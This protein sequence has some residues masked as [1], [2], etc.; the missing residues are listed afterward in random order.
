MMLPAPYRSRRSLGPALAGAALLHVTVFVLAMMLGRPALGPVGVAVPITVVTRGPTTDSRRAEAARQVQAAQTEEPQPD[1]RPPEPPPVAKPTPPRPKAA[2]VKTPP[3]PPRPI[4]TPKPSPPKAPPKTQAKP[5]PTKD[6]FSLEA[7]ARDVATVPRHTPPRPM[8]GQRG[9]TRA[10]TALAARPDAGAAQGVTQNDIA[11]LSQLLQ[12]LWNPNC[13]A[14]GGDSQVIPIK[15]E[16]DFE[17]R[18]SRSIN[19]GLCDPNA[20]GPRVAAACRAVDAIH[21]A[22]PYAEEYRGQKFT[23]N[24]DAKKAC[25]NR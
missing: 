25:A 15:I 17:G 19:R 11:G 21:R 3:P 24:F 4:P 2:P 9:P 14:E 22:E 8:S 1:A 13:A 16:V 12:R 10:E 5:Q 6:D 7:L 23:I 20:T 18:V